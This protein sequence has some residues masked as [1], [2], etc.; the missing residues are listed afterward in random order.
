[1]TVLGPVLLIA[2]LIWAFMRNRGGSQAEIDRAE[3]GA[4]DLREEIDQDEAR[5]HE[6]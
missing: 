5:R 1:M 2:V 3:R 4:R 6:N